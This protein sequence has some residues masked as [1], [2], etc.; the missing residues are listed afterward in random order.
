[1]EKFISRV[2]FTKYEYQLEGPNK[3]QLKDK[4]AHTLTKVAFNNFLGFFK[5]LSTKNQEA[6]KKLLG[7]NCEV[8]TVNA[9]GKASQDKATIMLKET[10]FSEVKKTVAK[11]RAT[12]RQVQKVLDYQA[13]KSVK[14]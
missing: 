7:E 5:L 6:F 13:D 10:I 3:D 4:P 12:F 1:L 11:D 14:A 8:K 2:L 9:N